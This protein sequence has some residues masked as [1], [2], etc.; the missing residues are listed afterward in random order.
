MPERKGTHLTLEDRY[1][2]QEG[3]VQGWSFRE[4]AR[5]LGVTPSTISREI[6]AN[7]VTKRKTS[8]HGHRSG[9]CANVS[10]CR[11]KGLCKPCKFNNKECKYCQRRSCIERCANYSAFICPQTKRAPFVCT[12]CKRMY[13]CTYT[14]YF[15]RAAHADTMAQ[16]RLRES[17]EGIDCTPADLE[18]MVSKV[19]RLLSQGHSL[20]AIWAI[21][22]SEFPV[23]VR[24]FYNYIERGVMG[25]ANIELPKKVAYRPRKKPDLIPRLDMKGRTY[26]D[27][28]MLPEHVRLNTVQMDCVEGKKSN[29]KTILTLHF[30]RF[31]FQFHILLE[32]KTQQKVKQ[33]LDAIE[34][35]C[36]KTFSD[37]FGILLTDRGSEF[38]DW[39]VIETGRKNKK[40][41]S[42][43]YC[44]PMKSGQK[45]SAEKNHV[46][47]RKILPKGKSNF[48]AL[49]FSDVA[50]ISSHVN[51]YPRTSLGGAT[52]YMLASQVLPKE[53]LDSLGVR[54]VP[55]DNVM[56]SP[57]LLER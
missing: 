9:V 7:R 4:I 28:L 16:K 22:G 34:I 52:P 51:S 42:L 26:A 38:L 40:R 48:D 5:R 50:E 17:R 18:L 47:L 10:H 2:I 12:K 13:H 11:V 36:N 1:V 44:D 21:Y 31:E 53:L 20:E 56:M 35:Y 54:R 27:Y 8:D 49:S 3:L 33:A 55:P 37:H 15:Y 29:N 57:R 41:C 43:Y 39:S 14:H 45:G 30:P 46:E 23:G 19:K 25:L 32:H 6:K 24:T